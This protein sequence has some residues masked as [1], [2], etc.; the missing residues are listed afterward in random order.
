[1]ADEAKEIIERT[2]PESGRPWCN[3]VC[4][5][6]VA[7]NGKSNGTVIDQDKEIVENDSLRHITLK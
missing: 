2:R 6:S 7:S 5:Q 3:E 4:T 1:M